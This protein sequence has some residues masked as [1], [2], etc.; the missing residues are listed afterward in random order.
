MYL[1]KYGKSFNYRDF[2]P[3][4]RAENFNADEWVSFVQSSGA[5][6]IMPVG[7][8]HDGFKMYNSDLSEWTSVNMGPKKD[9]LAEIKQACDKTGMIFFASSHRAEHFWFMN[10]GSTVGYDNETQNDKYRELYGEC[11]NVHKANNLFTMLKQEHGIEPTQEWLCD[12]L[13]SSCE[14]ID[15]YQPSSLFF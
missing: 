4:F 11:K 14:L 1:R 3:M 15:R 13:V 7:E 5:K 2:I 6:F 12:W 10:G 8:H 9:I